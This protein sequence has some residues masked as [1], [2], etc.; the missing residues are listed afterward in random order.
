[1]WPIFPAV[2]EEDPS[3]AGRI[4]SSH[5]T[6]IGLVV[7]NRLNRR[8]RI[9]DSGGFKTACSF[10]F[11][12]SPTY[13]CCERHSAAAKFCPT[14]EMKHMTIFRC[15]AAPD[16]FNQHRRHHA[17]SKL[18]HLKSAARCQVGTGGPAWQTHKV[19]DLGRRARLPPGPTL[20]ST[21]VDTPSDAAVLEVLQS[22][23]RLARR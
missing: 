7:E 22:N 17:R 9:V 15:R 16:F 14:I 11:Q 4:S 1:M 19:F 12:L 13:S 8:A 18:E 6:D 20:S 3:L 23:Y 10:S 2:C 5:N 21:T